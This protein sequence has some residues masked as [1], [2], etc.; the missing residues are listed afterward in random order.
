MVGRSDA[1][2]HR[3]PSPSASGRGASPVPP[4]ALASLPGCRGSRSHGSPVVSSPRSPTAD[5]TLGS[6]RLHGRWTPRS[7]RMWP[8]APTP[9]SPILYVGVLARSLPQLARFGIACLPPPCAGI[10]AAPQATR[11]KLCH[12]VPSSPGATGRGDPAFR[13]GVMES[14]PEPRRG[15]PCVASVSLEAAVDQG[16]KARKWPSHQGKRRPWD[17]SENS[18]GG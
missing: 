18:P 10:W 8:P 5:Y 2:G 14:P 13:H 4:P 3:S 7:L 15:V 16:F 1:T 9:R 6:L 12:A 11:W 17:P